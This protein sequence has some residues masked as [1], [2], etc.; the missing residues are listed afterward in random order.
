M[1]GLFP[2]LRPP[3]SERSPREKPVEEIDKELDRDGK[4]TAETKVDEVSVA[5]PAANPRVSVA[6]SFMS[7][8]SSLARAVVSTIERIQ[9]AQRDLMQ[10]ASRERR[11]GALP[12]QKYP[13]QNKA[14]I[15]IVQGDAQAPRAAR[16]GTGTLL[17]GFDA[18][19]LAEVQEMHAEKVSVQETFGLPLVVASGHFMRKYSFAGVVRTSPLNWENLED[20]EVGVPDSVK[21]RHFYDN[22]LRATLQAGRG[23]FTRVIVDNDAYDGWCTTF[24]ITRTAQTEYW[25]NFVFSFVAFDR[26]NI[27]YEDRAGKLF[28]IEY[29]DDE[30]QELSDA[31]LAAAVQDQKLDV[32]LKVGKEEEEYKDA[33]ET[34]KVRTAAVGWSPSGDNDPIRFNVFASQLS[35]EG[36]DGSEGTHGPASSIQS[37]KDPEI[38]PQLRGLAVRAGGRD[39]RG[40]STPTGETPLPVTVEVTDYLELY[41]SALNEASEESREEGGD[42]GVTVE[43]GLSPVQGAGATAIMRLRLAASDPLGIVLDPEASHFVAEANKPLKL[44]G[45]TPLSKK[46]P[47]DLGTYA[48]AAWAETGVGTLSLKLAFRATDPGGGGPVTSEAVLQGLTFS[49]VTLSVS[50]VL[51]NDVIASAD[52]GRIGSEL[53]VTFDNVEIE[54]GGDV[55]RVSMQ[56]T[57]PKLWEA[58]VFNALTCRAIKFE[59]P[60]QVDGPLMGPN[61]SVS[62]KPLMFR[63]KLP[64]RPTTSIW[65]DPT[66]GQFSLYEQYGRYRAAIFRYRAPTRGFTITMGEHLDILK[67][68]RGAGLRQAQALFNSTWRLEAYVSVGGW[69]PNGPFTWSGGTGARESR[70]RE[71]EVDEGWEHFMQVLNGGTQTAAQNSVGSLFYVARD[72][73]GDVYTVALISEWHK[74]LGANERALR[75]RFKTYHSARRPPEIQIKRVVLHLTEDAPWGGPVTL[76]AS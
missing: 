16:Q 7:L 6:S 48:D 64:V 19:V 55:P 42:L 30:Q 68:P 25:A 9:A 66:S 5:K 62:F 67:M 50:P 63:V 56:V 40:A 60:I 21:F 2:F 43:V 33:T 45:L 14:R 47:V 23:V 18:F 51:E 31:E 24:N 69:E 37:F 72:Q 58:E 59:L 26:Y 36:E 3:M 73:S 11:A 71:S 38:R 70:A 32:H 65:G 52:A 44:G 34:K 8:A 53:P 74:S 1:A 27:A 20:D 39:L 75:F 10:Q 76:E 35:E 22:H 57:I 29:P 28:D 12:P 61:Q 17:A 4:E 13:K 46:G 54:T 15:D 49:S 41:A